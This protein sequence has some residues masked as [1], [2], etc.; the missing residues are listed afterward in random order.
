MTIKEVRDYLIQKGTFMERDNEAGTKEK[1]PIED[2]R[3]S[4]RKLF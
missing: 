4:L 3:V 2:E 1:V